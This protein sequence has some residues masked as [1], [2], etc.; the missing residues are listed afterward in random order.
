MKWGPARLNVESVQVICLPCRQQLSESRC[1]NLCTLSSAELERG[2]CNFV[3][4]GRGSVQTTDWIVLP[5]VANRC[6]LIVAE[7][8]KSP[9][10]WK[11]I[12]VDSVMLPCLVFFSKVLILLSLKFLG[13][14]KIYLK[15]NI[16]GT[17]DAWVFFNCTYHINPYKSFVTSQLLRYVRP[18]WLEF[19]KFINLT[20]F[21]RIWISFERGMYVCMS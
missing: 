5:P 2:C 4:D 14:L 18:V 13:L 12:I 8:M 21:G 10:S 3:L 7:L 17:T 20:I 11:I 19:Y 15:N 16:F 9:S 6:I 1:H